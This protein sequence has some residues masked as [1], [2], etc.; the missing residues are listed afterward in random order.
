MWHCKVKV[1]NVNL[2]L[3]AWQCKVKVANVNLTLSAWQCKVKVA[4]VNLILSA[5][6]CKVKVANV[7]LTLRVCDFDWPC[8]GSP[9]YKWNHCRHE[10]TNIQAKVWRIVNV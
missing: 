6:H 10:L 1:A 8:I 7:N 4:N 9:E 5:W 2:T 3:S